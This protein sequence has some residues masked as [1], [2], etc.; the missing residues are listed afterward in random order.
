MQELLTRKGRLHG[1]SDEI[2]EKA[3][4]EISIVTDFSA[5]GSF[6][7]L[8]NNVTYLSSPGYAVLVRLTDFTRSWNGDFVYVPKHSYNFL[9]R[10]KLDVGDLVI[11][12]IGNAGT[13][14]QVPDLG[15]P[16]TLGPNALVIKTNDFPNTSRNYLYHY[17]R[18][19]DGQNQ[20][21]NLVTQSAQPKFNKTDFRNMKIP[22]PPLPE[23]I[24]IA[25][26]LSNMDAEISALEQKREKT[27][28]LKKGM[29]QELL[30][31]K[32]RLV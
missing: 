16:M 10:S 2:E 13:L 20:I 31:G 17:L 6:A 9:K 24:A 7:D 22:F 1:F 27:R 30:T 21:K 8:R 26:I 18:S 28:L 23:Q 4:G 32:T 5:N 15:M 12:N 25:E 29:M 19:D 3:I 11:S 14:F